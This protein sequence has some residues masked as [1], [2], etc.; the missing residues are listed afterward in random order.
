[1]HQTETDPGRL[2]ELAAVEAFTAWLAIDKQNHP[3]DRL[4]DI[5]YGAAPVLRSDLEALLSGIRTM[6]QIASDRYGEL[7]EARR[8]VAAWMQSADNDGLTIQKISR[9]RGAAQDRAAAAE[10]EVERLTAEL[11]KYVGWEPTVKDEYEHA[12]AQLAAVHAVVAAFDAGPKL[13]VNQFLADLKNALEGAPRPR[14]AQVWSFSGA[15]YDYPEARFATRELAQAAAEIQWRNENDPHGEPV[16]E[17]AEDEPG[18]FEAHID[19]MA[20]E[21]SV[22]AWPLIWSRDDEEVA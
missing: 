12:C 15:R 11:A 22:R 14:L 5:S 10:A 2:A 4:L 3:A 9:E 21:W 16:F 8:Q 19:G 13:A 20:L 1:M 18:V 7:S 17:W 6:A